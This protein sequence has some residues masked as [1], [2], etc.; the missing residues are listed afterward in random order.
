MNWWLGLLSSRRTQGVG[1]HRF[2][3]LWLRTLR[4][5]WNTIYSE[6]ALE[7]RS[8]ITSKDI[9]WVLYALLDSATGK[10]EQGPGKGVHLAWSLRAR[11]LSDGFGNKR[12]Y[13]TLSIEAAALGYKASWVTPKDIKSDNPLLTCHDSSSRKF[14]IWGFFESHF[15]FIFLPFWLL[16]VCTLVLLYGS[17][18]F[19]VN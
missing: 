14:C 7:R 17:S 6:H 11:C 16:C 12:A 13:Y 1:L 8:T 18:W 5:G 10:L 2:W 19:F 9:P 3:K 15:S 4:C